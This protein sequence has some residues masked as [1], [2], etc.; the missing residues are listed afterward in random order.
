MSGRVYVFTDCDLDGIGSYLVSKWLISDD[1][2]YT[3]TTCKNFRQDY[4]RWANHNK[5]SDYDKVFIFDINVS[6][7]VD[8]LDR[9]N[10]LVIDHHNG[11]DGYSEFGKA[12]LILE[13][14]YSS[15]CLLVLKTLL[16]L[17][18]KL[19]SKL[20]PE[21]A[22]MIKLV[23]DYDS[24]TLQYPESTGLNTILWSYTGNRVQK[25]IEEFGDGIKPFTSFQ[26]NMISIAEKKVKDAIETY[27]LFKIE[28]PIE[29]KKRKIV[30]IQCDH[31]INEVADGLLKKYNFDICFVVNLKSKS[32]SLRKSK[33]CDVNLNKL[34]TT[35][36]DGGGHPDSAGGK[37]T[38]TF[39]KCA[40]MFT[41]L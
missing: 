13:P 24:Y 30:S 33:G 21:R 9:S 19:K 17:N 31:N 35:L 26:K 12:K 23:D 32:V 6:E 16:A 18:P 7:H 29:G 27:D 34:A 8:L 3:V 25:F 36:C 37:I 10:I 15:T 41:K 14:E 28:L 39:L 5:L 1:M 4:L 11:K 22:K 40:K 2:P 20:T 38:D